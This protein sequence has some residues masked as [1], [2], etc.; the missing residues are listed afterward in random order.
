MVA[1]PWT[2]PVIKPLELTAATWSFVLNHVTF[3][4]G[5]LPPDPLIRVAEAWTEVPETMGLVAIVT[6]N[7]VGGAVEVP[8]PPQPARINKRIAKADD[9]IGD[10][11]VAQTFEGKSS[12]R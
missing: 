12:I 5:E 9:R 2:A 6:D 3:A 8:D 11:F 4:A 10:S 7:E 1:L